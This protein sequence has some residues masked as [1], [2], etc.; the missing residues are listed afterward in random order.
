MHMHTLQCFKGPKAETFPAH[1]APQSKKLKIKS[2]RGQLQPCFF[3]SL[4]LYLFALG[5]RGAEGDYGRSAKN[6]KRVM[7]AFQ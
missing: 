2:T 5:L 3:F 1:L 7:Y 6:I 4:S